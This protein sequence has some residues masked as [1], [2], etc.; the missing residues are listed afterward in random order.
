MKG[1]PHYDDYRMDAK[2]T[3]CKFRRW[4]QTAFSY[5]LKNTDT[6][7]VNTQTI[8]TLNTDQHPQEIKS[9]NF[10][11]ELAMESA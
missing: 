7:R 10:T 8:Y 2:S 3:T 9:T 4:T 5:L 11:F 6:M 1:G